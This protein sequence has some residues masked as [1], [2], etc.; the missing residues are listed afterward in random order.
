M[1][2][3][4]RDGEKAVI[5]EL[6]RIAS[7]ENLVDRKMYFMGLLTREAEKRG[8][9]PIVVGGS[10]V[11]FYTEGIFPSY[12]IDLVGSREI[13]GEILEKTFNFKPIGRHWVNEQIGLFIEIPGTH[14]AGDIDKIVTIRIEDLTVYVLGLE[15][16]IMDRIRACVYWKSQ[17]D[18]AQARFMIGQY[19]NRLDLRYL[20]K[21]A[22]DEYLLKVLKD[23]SN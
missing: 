9:R 3:R 13:I 15:D 23:L 7:I 19:Q 20:E 5:P 11:D 6:Q 12:D 4:E 21:I 18:C 16:L 14:P 10:A 17:T 1:D 8:V 22:R 2:W